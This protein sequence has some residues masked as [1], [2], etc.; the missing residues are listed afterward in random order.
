MRRGEKRS[1]EIC[2]S[3]RRQPQK[4]LV[5]VSCRAFLLLRGQEP[6]AGHGLPR[7]R[8]ACCSAGRKLPRGK[9]S[10]TCCRMGYREERSSIADAGRPGNGEKGLVALSQGAQL[11]CR[12]LIPRGWWNRL[13]ILHRAKGHTGR[14]RPRY[15]I[16]AA[17]RP[18][19]PT[20]KRRSDTGGSDFRLQPPRVVALRKGTFLS[21]CYSSPRAEWKRLSVLLQPQGSA[22][23]Q[24]PRDDRAGRCLA[25][26][27]D[28]QRQ[29]YTAAG[30]AR[31]PPQGLVALR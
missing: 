29:P 17:C 7:L 24:R 22:R 31:Q 12:H 5:A 26:A 9:V 25:M 2:R 4:G 1:A 13:P 19:G 15:P 6:R 8:G 16:P 18:M 20:E 3:D 27:P 28:A 11:P 21:G 10:R 23:L 14:K 30:D